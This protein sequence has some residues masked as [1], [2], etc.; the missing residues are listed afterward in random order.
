MRT[1]N[2]TLTSCKLLFDSHKYLQIYGENIVDNQ[3]LPT[4]PLYV[5]YEFLIQVNHML[6]MLDLSLYYFWF[7][8]IPIQILLFSY[9]EI[10][11]LV[12]SWNTSIYA[13]QY[14]HRGG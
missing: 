1:I 14:H 4:I 5:I 2:V 6:I 11:P 12:P 3:A 9:G 10:P 7:G 8:V 13:P